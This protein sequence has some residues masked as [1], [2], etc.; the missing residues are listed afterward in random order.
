MARHIGA[1]QAASARRLWSI[2]REMRH[3]VLA[4][5][6]ITGCGKAAT[7]D[8]PTSNGSGSMTKMNAGTAHTFS[9]GA[10]ITPADKLVEWLDGAKRDGQARLLRVPVVISRGQ[11]GFDT[12]KVTIGANGPAVFLDD[13]SMGVGISDRAMQKC[14]DAQTCAFMVEGY[15]RGKQGQGYQLDINKA[16]PLAADALAAATFV[17]VEGESAN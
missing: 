8:K 1:W 4:V 9:Q 5:L 11:V 14:G 16:E 3:A 17:E 13:S 12:S 15:W 2:F 6:M 7:V 10:P